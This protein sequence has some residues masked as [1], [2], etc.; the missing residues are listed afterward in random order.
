MNAQNPLL[1]V[2]GALLVPA[3]GFSMAVGTFG[4]DPL[5]FLVGLA[6]LAAGGSLLALFVFGRP[7]RVKAEVI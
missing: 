1:G 7:A 2:M 6:L 3:A 5:A 4:G